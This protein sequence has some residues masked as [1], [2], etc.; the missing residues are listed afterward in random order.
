VN[1][2]RRFREQ[3]FRVDARDTA[4]NPLIPGGITELRTHGVSGAPPEDLVNDPHPLFVA[5]DE[6][7]GF[8]R[9][10]GKAETPP[11]RTVEA[12]SWSGINSGSS[13]RAFLLLLFPFAM[14]NHAG[15]MVGPK[16]KGSW[17]RALIR[18]TGLMFTVQYALWAM[19]IFV[20]LL[21]FQCGRAPLCR[22]HFWLGWFNAIRELAGPSV[23]HQVVVFSAFPMLAI[24]ILFIAGRANPRDYERWPDSNRAPPNRESEADCLI[25]RTPLRD[26]RFWQAPESAGAQALAHCGAALAVVGATLAATVLLLAEPGS[27]MLPGIR[28]LEIGLWALA[29]L[30]VLIILAAGTFKQGSRGSR[31]WVR[32]AQAVGILVILQVVMLGWTAWDVPVS[33]AAAGG[34]TL[35]GLQRSFDSVLIVQFALLML[36]FLFDQFRM[37]LA[38]PVIGSGLFWALNRGATA[39]IAGLAA[40]PTLL[41]LQWLGI[42]LIVGLACLAIYLVRN[43]FTGSALP[44]DVDADPDD[45]AR[46]LSN[47]FWI[48]FGLAP[49]VVTSVLSVRAAPGPGQR[50][51]A[52]LL[53]AALCATYLCL[54][55]RIQIRHCHDYAP[56]WRL[57]VGGPGA[58]VAVGA[59]ALTIISAA[60][61]VF[62]AKGL[63][64][65]YPIGAHAQ[66]AG[67]AVGATTQIPV[68]KAG[69]APIGYYDELGWIAATGLGALIVFLL[70]LIT[71][72]ACL[73]RFRFKGEVGQI[74]KALD[75]V[76]GIPEKQRERLPTRKAKAQMYAGLLDDLD[77]TVSVGIVAFLAT[78]FSV[79]VGQYL[80]KSAGPLDGFVGL[81]SGLLVSVAFLMIWVVRTA[82]KDTGIRKAIG[83]LWEISSFFPRRFHPLAPPSY[84][85]RAVPELR[86]RLLMLTEADRQVL[87]VAH[88]QGTLLC[89]AVLQSLLGKQTAGR[90]RRIRFIT[91][92]CMLQRSYGR[93]FPHLV[94]PED[95][96]ELKATLEGAEW[97]AS[98]S[99]DAEFPS[100]VPRPGS[101]GPMLARWMNF[102]RNTDFLGGRM[103]VAPHR[104]PGCKSEEDR[105]DDIFFDDPP[106]PERFPG[107]TA[108][109]A[110][111]RHSFN[112]NDDQED[113]RFREHVDSTLSDMADLARGAGNP[114]L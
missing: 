2:P 87:L 6:K 102:G 26:P 101:V 77:W 7:A 39:P 75:E 58:L 48:F 114:V 112:Y 73:W 37:F 41:W 1:K 84:G 40:G 82:Q 17:Q 64:N 106:R 72:I 51:W 34:A 3:Y 25:D 29:A 20:D 95:L 66:P 96:M 81:A 85:E 18:L 76:G 91:Y 80:G 46:H 68:A 43:R 78:S 63:G 47:Q 65:G 62:V 31:L 23:I 59:V 103:F 104:P 93:S 55:S 44:G 99:S 110:L 56:T 28:H 19:V 108:E 113:E 21:A 8:Y 60:V 90:L 92:G 45:P 111:L 86:N 105:V 12:Y 5:G 67:G 57:R 94:R 33:R 24:A 74:R 69:K 50:V 13:S 98:R 70:G 53:G 54:A 107:E 109:A 22:N 100:P 42:G 97:T 4:G 27:T 36:F 61:I 88:S 10:L 71:R 83:T 79:V 11:E 49:L 30:E 32:G 52:S 14:A 38:I 15:W 35:A 16:S 9:R 89:A